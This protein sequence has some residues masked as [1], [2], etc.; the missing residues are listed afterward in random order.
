MEPI[1]VTEDD[2]RGEQHQ[3]QQLQS[4]EQCSL[5]SGGK[6]HHLR[7]KW[8]FWHYRR[9]KRTTKTWMD[10]QRELAEIETLENFWTFF[11]QLRNPSMVK[12]NQDYALFKKGIKPMWEDPANVRGGQWIF[13]IQKSHQKYRFLVDHVWNEIVLALICSIFKPSIMDLVCGIVF[14]MRISCFTKISIWIS[15]YK[16]VR[17]ILVLGHELKRITNFEDCVIFRRNDDMRVKFIL[18]IYCGNKQ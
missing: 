16:A 7:Y 5:L 10:C 2:L 17:E 6:V 4:T 11:V 18:W 1:E 14:S 8:I 3:H 15:D 9:S 13:V 12:I